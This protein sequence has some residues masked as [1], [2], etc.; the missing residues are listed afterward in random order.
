MSKKVVVNIKI[1]GE[2]TWQINAPMEA[3]DIDKLMQLDTDSDKIRKFFKI[4][5]NEK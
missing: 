2:D 3:K 4:L 5:L 1:D